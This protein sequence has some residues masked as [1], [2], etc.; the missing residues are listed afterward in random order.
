M[1]NRSSYGDAFQPST[2]KSTKEHK[3]F[4][5]QIDINNLDALESLL[6]S[7]YKRIENGEVV[8]Q[9]LNDHTPWDDSGSITTMNWNKYNVFQFYDE[10]IHTLFRA[11]KD[12]TVDACE[13]YGLDF[14]QEQ[15]MVQGWFNVNYNHIGKLDWHEHGGDGAPYF[16]GYYC[17]KAEPS[18]THYRVFEKEIENHNRNNRAILSET[19]HPH[20]MGDWDWDGPRITIAYDVIPL[21]Y[22]PK[23]W[24]QHW[25]PMV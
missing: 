7:Q 9:K 3:F 19:G 12:M 22:I 10:N 5:R 17:V 23:E 6:L 25:I 14:V 11:V 8:K 16:H 4:E 21:R 18:V 1:E 2:S 15:F 20:A 13:H 24:E